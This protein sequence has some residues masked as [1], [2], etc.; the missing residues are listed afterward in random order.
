MNGVIGAVDLILDTDLLPDQ[1]EYL[2]IASSSAE[3]LLQV[4]ND[5]L[6][7]SKVESGKLQLEA[8]D[9]DFRDCLEDALATLEHSR[10]RQRLAVGLRY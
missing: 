2:Q 5:I 9:F 8:I 6:D 1:R 3:A 10:G 7:F 4:I